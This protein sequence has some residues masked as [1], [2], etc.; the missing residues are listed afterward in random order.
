MMLSNN[1][2]KCIYSLSYRM[3]KTNKMRNIFVIIAIIITTTMMTAIFNISFNLS[4]QYDLFQ[5]RQLGSAAQIIIQDADKNVIDTVKKSPD[6][7][8]Y[9]LFKEV[10]KLNLYDSDILMMYYDENAYELHMLPILSNVE[11]QYPTK[12]NE[13]MLSKN[14][15]DILKIKD[16]TMGMKILIDNQEYKLSG[17][18]EQYQKNVIYVS[19]NYMQKYSS[20]KKFN[21][22]EGVSLENESRFINDLKNVDQQI[23]HSMKFIRPIQNN[24][25]LSSTLKMGVLFALIVVISGYLLIYNV[26]YISII[27]D[28]QFYGL[29]CTIGMTEKQVKRIVMLQ[30]LFLSSVGILLGLILGCIA[31]YWVVP[32]AVDMINQEGLSSLT[33]KDVRIFPTANMIACLFS[34][35]VV[36]I[37]ARKPAKNA[38]KISPVLAMK[39]VNQTNYSR[40]VRRTKNNGKLYKL[41]FSNIFRNKKKA[42]IVFASL[43][44]GMSLYLFAAAFFQSID[45]D[46]FVQYSCPHDYMMIS[47]DGSQFT[48]DEPFIESIQKIDKQMNLEKVKAIKC[49]YISHEENT[50]KEAWCMVLNEQ[51]IEQMIPVSKRSNFIAGKNIMASVVEDNAILAEEYINQ[52][53][54]F[55]GNQKSLEVQVAGMVHDAQVLR[56]TTY[57]NNPLDSFGF[58]VSEKFVERI[59]GQPQNLALYIDSQKDI[60]SQLKAIYQDE[61]PYLFMAQKD[62]LSEFQQSLSSMN[63]LATVVSLTLF[64]IGIINFV[65]VMI[66][67]I[68]TRK[69]EL[70]MME[71]IGMTQHQILKLLLYE[72]IYYFLIVTGLIQIVG[73]M[74]FAIIKLNIQDMVYYAS[75][76][77]PLFSMCCLEV[78]LLFVC[79][80]VPIL[81]YKKIDHGNVSERL[82]EIQE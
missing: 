70:A 40:K 62:V 57:S 18:F 66:T 25:L 67:N 16:P 33:W 65:N 79:T 53:L 72:G 8:N 73:N 14:M 3:L 27:K 4:H 47:L 23:E 34:L 77:Y 42:F 38:S 28:T 46:A 63:L 29:L 81:V 41:A 49:Q 45:D 43:I 39:N 61:S 68:Y 58:V 26:M 11:G 7:Q 55:I 60:S 21:I 12:D 36:F 32:I 78:I 54:R 48:F 75:F 37:G 9:G 15:L 17:W 64:F 56:V 71:S 59:Q 13:V 52:N 22:S 51:Q 5:L 19:Q 44:F 69:K 74:I 30:T 6:I 82:R 24:S 80:L 31:S 2:Q 35:L 10:R 50:T 76:Q 20:H 1:N